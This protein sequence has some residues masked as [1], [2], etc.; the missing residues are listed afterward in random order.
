[1]PE[2]TWF[3]E[4]DLKGKNEE[5]LKKFDAKSVDGAKDTVLFYLG[6]SEALAMSQASDDE[7]KQE[8]AEIINDDVEEYESLAYFIEVRGNP[9]QKVC[10]LLTADDKKIGK[11]T[12]DFEPLSEAKQNVYMEMVPS[13]SEKIAYG[14]PNTDAEFFKGDLT[15]KGPLKLATKPRSW[16]EAYFE[17]NDREI[18]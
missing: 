1:M 15:V 7:D 9:D 18:D 4:S 6:F 5:Y 17:F 2:I 11:W 10:M 3:T 13:C 12:G 14:N 16:I 8:L